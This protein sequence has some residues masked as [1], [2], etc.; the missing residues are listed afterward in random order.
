MDDP[1]HLVCLSLGSN[2]AP[3][4]NLKL[5]L[6]LLRQELTVLAVSR[7]W[8]TPAVGSQGPDFLNAAVLVY[9][10]QPAS[11]LKN[12]VLRDIETR[13]GRIRS[14]D[15]YAPRTIDIDI[16]VDGEQVIDPELWQHAHLAQPVAELLPDLVDPSSGQTLEVIADHLRPLAGIRPCPEM[17]ECE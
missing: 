12:Q 13:L 7:A 15:K 16:V 10:P 11:Q 8:R 2:I 4:D 1:Q 5:A 17:L 3:A 6:E 14:E 9:A